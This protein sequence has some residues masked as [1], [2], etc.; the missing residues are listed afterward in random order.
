MVRFCDST[1]TDKTCLVSSTNAGKPKRKTSGSTASSRISSCPEPRCTLALHANDGKR[2][3]Q[4]GPNP[5]TCGRKQKLHKSQENDGGNGLVGRESEQSHGR[6]AN[7]NAAQLYQLS[8][9]HHTTHPVPVLLC[10][11]FS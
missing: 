8:P 5:N 1:E 7:A 6:L 4:Q 2:L 11:D 3:T 9:L 10:W